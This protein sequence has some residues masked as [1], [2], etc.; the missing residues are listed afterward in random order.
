MVP[1]NR[2]EKQIRRKKEK[3]KKLL[4]SIGKGE[5]EIV[6]FLEIKHPLSKTWSLQTEREQKKI[7]SDFNL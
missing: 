5:A 1:S 2:K 6:P 3:K 7:A 4:I